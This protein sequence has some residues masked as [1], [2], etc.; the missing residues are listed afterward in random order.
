MSGRGSELVE[1]DVQS[2]PFTRASTGNAQT[3]G[4]GIRTRALK[5]FN[6]NS[7]CL[8]FYIKKNNESYHIII[9]SR[10]STNRV[11]K[12]ARLSMFN[13]KENDYVVHFSGPS[14]LHPLRFSRI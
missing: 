13:E 11:R 14:N 8:Q 1:D 9:Y 7:L 3:N 2:L 6:N 5:E 10:T 12:I 4:Y